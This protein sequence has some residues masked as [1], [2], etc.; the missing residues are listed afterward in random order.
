MISGPIDWRDREAAA[1][2]AALEARRHFRACRT[3]SPAGDLCELGAGLLAGVNR[4]LRSFGD[5]MATRGR[6]AAALKG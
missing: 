6:I 1:L 5:R 2:D 4:D 3:C